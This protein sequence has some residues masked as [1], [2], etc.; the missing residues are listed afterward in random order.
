ML[1]K[2][3]ERLQTQVERFGQETDRFSKT[4]T[5]EKLNEIDPET[6]KVVIDETNYSLNKEVE[7]IITDWSISCYADKNEQEEL[8]AEPFENFSTVLENYLKVF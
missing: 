8:F 1:N 6:V 3:I 7:L 4:I 5:L 2:I